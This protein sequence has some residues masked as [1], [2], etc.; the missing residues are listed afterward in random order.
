LADRSAIVTGAGSGIGAA[1]A[2]LL[3]NRGMTVGLVGRRRETLEEVAA[4]LDAGPGSALVIQEDL[5]DAGAPRRIVDT[6]LEHAGRL[7]VIVNNAGH[8]RLTP[9]EDVS[10]EELDEHFAVNLRAPY[11]LVRAALPALKASPAAVVVNVSSA[12]AA[13]YR[14][15]Q[16][17]YAMTKAGLE[18]LTK[19]LAAEL[20]PHGIR[21]NC[22]RPGPVDTPIHSTAVADPDARLQELG[23]LVPLGRVGQPEEIAAWI[24]HLVDPDGRW[25]TGS[26]LVIDGGRVLGP[27]E[28]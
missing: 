2:R 23:R 1:T 14:P 15:G 18:H 10:A 28:R 20:A 11:L 5:A 13:M 7:D 12:A 21:V 16:T 4:D 26:V 17:V 8:L 6:V 22:I 3:G 24:G 27:P 9:V 25:V 19:N